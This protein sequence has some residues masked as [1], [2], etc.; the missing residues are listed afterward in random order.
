MKPTI[1][2]RARAYL[3]RMPVSV[4]G[5]GGH[6][7][8]FAAALALVKGFNLPE[9]ETMPLLSEWNAQCFPPWSEADLRHKLKSAAASDRP[10][11]YLVAGDDQPRDRVTPDHET[12]SERKARLR[13]SWPEFKRLKPAG[14]EMI[15]KLRGINI[16]A[17]DLANRC[18]LLR[19]AVIDGHPSFIIT[20]G[21]FSQA[22]RLDG[23]PFEK[24]DGSKIKAKN[25]SGSEG[26]FIGRSWL[27]AAQHVLL[28]EG[29]I[30][31]V[32][33]MAALL[34][35]YV[36][37]EEPWGV[38]AATSAGS[39]FARA[40][41][42]LASLASRHIRIIPDNNKTGMDAAASW[43]AD[44]EGVGA[45]VEIIT[46]PDRYGDLGDLLKDPATTAK[47]LTPLFQ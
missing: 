41:D 13:Q 47:T 9:S 39:R 33:A 18:G 45:K 25:L 23:Q 36:A 10:H 40:P 35:S 8:A 27:C 5:Q 29:C 7:A 11:G 24:S 21:A 26:A 28:V 34:P 14:V 4:S 30:G 12:E 1:I 43:L 44:L 3:A 31:L 17:V 16:D 38:I 6:T 46:L 20:E 22:R 19:G 15:A 2:E 37:T 42:L 32:E